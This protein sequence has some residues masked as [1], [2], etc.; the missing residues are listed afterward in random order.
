MLA[1]IIAETARWTMGR[2][3]LNV[4]A[5]DAKQSIARLAERWIASSLALPY[6]N[7]TRLS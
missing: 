1:D 7:A 4:I 3:P 2:R 5:S 6:A